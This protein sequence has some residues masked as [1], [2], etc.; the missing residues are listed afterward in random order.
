MTMIVTMVVAVAVAVTMTVTTVLSWNWGPPFIG[1]TRF[2][3]SISHSQA[4]I[5]LKS[6]ATPMTCPVLHV[7]GGAKFVGTCNFREPQNLQPSRL[8]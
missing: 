4:N 1:G 5:L 6:C 3:Y 7:L 2:V 8:W